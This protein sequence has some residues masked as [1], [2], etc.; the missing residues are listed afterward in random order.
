METQDYKY[1]AGSAAKDFRKAFGQF[2]SGKTQRVDTLKPIEIQLDAQEDVAGG[3]HTIDFD[4]GDTR[5]RWI[6]FW[7][8]VNN[9]D[10]PNSN[11][12]RVLTDSQE[13]DVIPLNAVIPLNRGDNMNIMMAAEN[14]TEGI[15]I[16]CIEPDGEPEIPSIIV[17][18]VQLD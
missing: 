12:R 14:D 15:G 5:N 6:D 1:G 16:E 2:S 11:I 9:V 4:K 18:I 3:V 7:L 8:R 10:V 17:T 13:K